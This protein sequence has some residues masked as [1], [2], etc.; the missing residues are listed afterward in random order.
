MTM[1]KARIQIGNGATEDTFAAHKLIYFD[2]DKRTEAPVKKRDSSSYIEK[3]GEHT[4]PR[5]VQDSF[6]Y[7]VQFIIDAWD[8]DLDNVNAIVAAFNAKLYAQEENSGIR[9]FK[10]VAFYNDD[11]RVKIVGLPDP[12]AEPKELHRSRNGYDFAQVELVIHVGDPTKC[13]FNLTR[14]TV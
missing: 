11:R 5:T 14:Q 3:P 4:D 9:V 7:K 1:T 13:D 2:A 10:E 12:I 6:D 8:R